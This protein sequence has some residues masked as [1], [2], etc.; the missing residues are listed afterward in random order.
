MNGVLRSDAVLLFYE[1]G[2]LQR[3]NTTAFEDA[4]SPVSDAAAALRADRAAC[5]VVTDLPALLRE[6]GESETAGDAAGMS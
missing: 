3:Y 6:L 4:C 1:G 5:I 2:E